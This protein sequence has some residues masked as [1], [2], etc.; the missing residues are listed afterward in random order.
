MTTDFDRTI[1]EDLIF[2]HFPNEFNFT[3]LTEATDIQ[4]QTFLAARDWWW[5]SDIHC[6]FNTDSQAFFPARP[7]GAARP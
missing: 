7:A 1:A 3:E 5:H 4:L 6:F 2:E